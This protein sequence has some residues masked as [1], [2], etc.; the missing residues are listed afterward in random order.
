MP[1]R[2]RM[3]Y[4][5]MTFVLLFI[6]AVALFSELSR[7]SDIWWTP[8]PLAL[9]LSESTDRV[10]VY[11]RGKPLGSLLDAGQLK[12]AGTPDSVLSI[13]DVR[14]RLNNWDRVR[15]QRLPALLVYAAAI[16]AGALLFLLL[17]TNRLAYR[18]EGKVT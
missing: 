17:I 18:G 6:P 11:V 3:F 8:Q 2:I 16:G 12:L 15:A 13:S 5:A 1:P 10:Q 14:F 7:R 9:S 4:A